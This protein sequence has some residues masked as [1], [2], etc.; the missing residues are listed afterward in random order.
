MRHDIDFS[1]EKALQLATIEAD[2]GIIASYFLLFS[3]PFYNLQDPKNI[4]IPRK[5][6]NLGHEVGLHYDN[7]ALISSATSIDQS[8]EILD[9]QAE[10]LGRFSG[11]KVVTIAAH[12]P[13]ISGE[14]LLKSTKYSS[15]YENRFVSE[16]AYFSDS[17]G[18]W[19]N[20]FVDLMERAA[21]PPKIQL[22]THPFFWSH[23]SMD[24][25]ETLSDYIENESDLQEKQIDQVKNIWANH[26][27]VKEHDERIA[28]KKTNK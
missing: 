15:V 19:R 26:S 8:S 10:L 25:Y 16:I 24:R 22:L 20:D 11:E 9:S 4:E 14:E 21:M 17:C 2:A 6:T 28:S 12:N 27:G 3:S 23:K 1:L 7:D 18:A 5:L 13:S